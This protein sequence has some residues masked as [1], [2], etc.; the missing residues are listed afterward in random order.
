MSRNMERKKDTRTKKCFQ[1]ERLYLD[2]LSNKYGLNFVMPFLETFVP[3]NS[4][5]M[6]TYNFIY[7]QKILGDNSNFSEE[8]FIRKL[9]EFDNYYAN[10][11]AVEARM[12]IDSQKELESLYEDQ[13]EEDI[14]AVKKKLKE[15][16]KKITQFKTNQKQIIKFYQLKKD[17]KS[18]KK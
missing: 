7:N 8:E 4:A 6:S 3:Y 10:N 12:A 5:K 16:K 14:K 13:I 9:F 17:G 1:S 18:I 15:T 2:E 11:I